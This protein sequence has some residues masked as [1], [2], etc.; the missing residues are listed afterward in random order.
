MWL[1]HTFPRYLVTGIIFGRKILNI[2]CAFRFSLQIL[3]ETFLFPR[4][5]QRDI[6]INVQRDIIINVQRDIIINVQRD[7][8]IN[9]QRD[10][11]INVHTTSFKVPIFIV[12]F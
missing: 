12:G 1:C 11:I 2:K 4:I 7:I 6:I 8:I 3:S 9:V 5:I 10:I